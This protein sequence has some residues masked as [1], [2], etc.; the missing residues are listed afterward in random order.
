MKALIDPK[1]GKIL[2]FTI[3]RPEAGEVKAVV[4][5]ANNMSRGKAAY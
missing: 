3:I 4:Q 2:G 1:D 5:M